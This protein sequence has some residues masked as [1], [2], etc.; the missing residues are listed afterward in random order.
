[1]KVKN[2]DLDLE[3]N[4]ITSLRIIFEGLWS[5]P[6]A[7]TFISI[8]VGWFLFA[9]LLVRSKLAQARKFCAITPSSLTTLGILGTFIGILLG[10][11]QFDV[12]QIEKSVP[13]LLDGMKLAFTTSITGIATSLAFKGFSAFVSRVGDAG[14][15]VTPANI[16]SEL[17]NISKATN[18]AAIDNKIAMEELRAAISS[19]TDS[20]L[21]T[22][23]QKLRSTVSD[24]QDE[25]IKEFKEFA[26]NMAENN[27]KALIEALE[28][29]IRDFNEKLT[30]QFGEN[31][32][33]LNQAVEKLV[34]WQEEYRKQLEIYQERLDAAVAALESTEEAIQNIEESAEKI[35]EA[36]ESLDPA[37]KMLIDQSEILA[38][39][40]KSIQTLREKT[41][42]AFPTI[43]QNLERITS[44]FSENVT[45]LLD[46]S[47]EAFDQSQKSF[48]T[49][50]S[51]YDAILET[52]K[53]AQ[54][55]YSETLESAVSKMSEQAEQQFIKHGQLIETS[56]AQSDKAIQEAWTE[57]AKKM[58]S[59]F[60]NFDKEM[61]QELSRAMEQLGKSLASISE[62]F[63]S[64]YTPL[65]QKLQQLVETAKRVN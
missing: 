26:A 53:L 36:V 8:I 60:E 7:Q 34:V 39:S 18:D 32:K 19:E 20:S 1:M 50:S 25:L 49:L 41:D 44:G 29:V 35:P 24:G 57:T 56:A 61:Q 23:M 37:L 9:I 65:T 59:Q 62:K 3:P 43:E 52:A 21:V 14:E 54:D 4:S 16:L 48:S 2:E 38:E 31:F 15:Q 58:S 55:K 6:V 33:Q 40:L 45:G 47:S 22:Q 28:S 46:K 63:V 64:D 10:L 30:E 17:E 12:N 5:D 11:A 13:A 51:G 27:Q 42:E